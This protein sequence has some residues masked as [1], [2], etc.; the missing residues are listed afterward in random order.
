M[1]VQL[2]RLR[3]SALTG[4]AIKLVAI[5]Q[6]ADQSAHS[7]GLTLPLDPSSS[8]LGAGWLHQIGT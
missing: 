2:G 4:D 5:E 3:Q 8:W 1:P 7:K 6:S